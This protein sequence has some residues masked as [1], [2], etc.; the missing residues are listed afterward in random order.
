MYLV[1]VCVKT[2]A[3]IDGQQHG[4]RQD[5]L[6]EVRDLLSRSIFVNQE[7]FFIQTPDDS[8]SILLQHQRIDFDQINIHLNYVGALWERR[9][10]ARIV[11]IVGR[12]IRVD[13][14]VGPL[15]SDGFSRVK[16][17]GREDDRG[18]WQNKEQ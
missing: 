17:K 13:S 10:S 12:A 9:N 16:K 4:K 7:I 18:E 1:S 11:F 6:T 2:G 5:V 3:A 15:R 14:L 8:R